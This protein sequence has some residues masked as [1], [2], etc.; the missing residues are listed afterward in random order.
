MEKARDLF[1]KIRD[2]KGNFNAKMGTIKDRN[3]MDL[4]EAEDIKKRWQEYTEELYKKDLHDPDNHNG[5]ISHLEP[6]I[7]ECEVK[8]ALR[9]ITMNKASGGDGIPVELFQIL[10]DDAVKVWHSICQKIWKTQQWPQDWKRSVF[11]RITKKSNAKECS[12]YCTIALISHASKVMLKILQA[13]LQ[14]YVNRELPDVQAGFR[15]GRRTRDKIANIRWIIAREF[16]KNV[17]FC[18]IDYAKGFDCVDRNKQWKILQ[19]MGIPD[20]L[21]CLLRNRCAGQEATE[22]DVK[23]QTV[24]KSGKEYIKALYCHPAYL[25]YMQSSVQFSSGAQS[26]PI[27][28]DLMNRSTPGLPVHHQ[29]PFT[30]THVH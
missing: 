12:G 22:L 20:H 25:I 5:V 27:L 13:R 15:K 23:K 16:Q 9:S 11:I 17:Y 29:L 18:F 4:T 19:E 8:W 6:N 28:C 24:S 26:C 1:K 30:Q 3:G 14:Q 21:T 10:K 2:T 7:L